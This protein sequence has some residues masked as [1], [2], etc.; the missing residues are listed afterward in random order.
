MIHLILILRGQECDENSDK[1]A[2]VMKSLVLFAIVAILFGAVSLDSGYAIWADEGPSR[3]ARL[4]VLRSFRPAAGTLAWVAL[5]F[6]TDPEMRLMASLG[7]SRHPHGYC[8]WWWIF[9]TS[10]D[11]QHFDAAFGPGWCCFT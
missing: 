11:P 4:F 2:A 9:F 8:P 3:A 5:S 7:G 6:R 10:A 1:K